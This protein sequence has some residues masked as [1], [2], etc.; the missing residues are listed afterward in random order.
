MSSF[1]CGYLR[2][3]TTFTIIEIHTFNKGASRQL[4][5]FN[6]VSSS[7]KNE[8]TFYHQFNADVIT[9][10]LELLTEQKFKQQDSLV[11]PGFH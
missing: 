3:T 10:F 8:L 11:K 6:N 7:T 5:N 1:T 2:P 4:L 9:K